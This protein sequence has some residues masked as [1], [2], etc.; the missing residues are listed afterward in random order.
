[1]ENA[2]QFLNPPTLHTKLHEAPLPSA[3][4]LKR[5]LGSHYQLLLVIILPQINVPPSFENHSHAHSEESYFL[6]YFGFASGPC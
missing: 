2:R 5:P 6:S 3:Q 1:M 4:I